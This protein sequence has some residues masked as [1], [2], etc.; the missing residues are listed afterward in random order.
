M[1]I[2]R[3]ILKERLSPWVDGEFN[4]EGSAFPHLAFDTDLPPVT[5][6]NTVGGGKTQSCSLANILRGEKGIKDTSE[7]FFS[8]AFACIGEFHR[9]RFSVWSQGKMLQRPLSLTQ[10]ELVNLLQAAIREGILSRDF[11]SE[12]HSVNEI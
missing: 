7:V 6:D 2:G 9:D 3:L 4:G 5:L 11:T 1:I 10:K 12:L 8:D